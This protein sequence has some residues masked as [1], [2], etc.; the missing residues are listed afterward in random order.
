VAV[1]VL[2][3]SLALAELGLQA[4]A[5]LSRDR[6]SAWRPG[7]R[8]RVL[9]VGDSHTYG[10]G[11]ARGDAY[12]AGLQH[13]LDERAPGDHSV[14]YLGLPG[15]SSTQLRNRLPVWVQRYAPTLVVAWVGVND[16]WNDAELDAQ[17]GAGAGWLDAAA[18]RSRLYRLL[19]VRLHDRELERYAARSPEERAWRVEKLEGGLHDQ[20]YTVRH[21]GVTERIAH[22]PHEAPPE[23]PD[24]A[25]A[26]RVR[27]R[28]EADLA[29]MAAWLRD[30]GIPL[31]LVTYPIEASW[32]R[33]ANQA[34]RAVAARY[35]LA[36]VESAVAIER[37]PEAE[38]DWIW[39]AHPGARIYREIAAEVAPVVAAP[40]SDLRRRFP[41]RTPAFAEISPFV[42]A[43]LR[44]TDGALVLD[45][46][47]P[48]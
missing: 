40:G 29:A 5:R 37:I 44:D 2:V 24:D 46:P 6:A 32:Y 30:A 15:L 19:R 17:P 9:C 7:A 43:P 31:V 26:A 13:L 23:R 34:A 22:G 14:V 16:A 10:A 39:A 42:F 38:Q 47:E 1:G 35:D 4:A 8:N 33:I 28:I 27:A 3:G 36:L 21:D 12:P 45:P 25:G 20:V 41:P 48:P 18:S 11:V